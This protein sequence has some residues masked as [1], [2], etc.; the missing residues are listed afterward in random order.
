[1]SSP[2]SDPLINERVYQKDQS[3]P[4]PKQVEPIKPVDKT[5]QS[6]AKAIPKHEI[7]KPPVI[8]LSEADLSM[9]S[10]EQLAALASQYEEGSSN[11]LEIIAQKKSDLN[12][13]KT[14][15]PR[16]SPA[17]NQNPELHSSLREL[18]D[19]GFE[20]ELDKIA[21][22]I[23]HVL[24]AGETDLRS[25]NSAA[26]A[27]ISKINVAVSEKGRQPL[28][29]MGQRYDP[30]RGV[31]QV[32]VAQ[33]HA[34]LYQNRTMRHEGRDVPVEAI[35]LHPDA[36]REMLDQIV[37]ALTILIQANQEKEKDK[38]KGLEIGGKGVIG[39]ESART[40]EPSK[41]DTIKP[42][43]I[44][45]AIVDHLITAFSAKQSEFNKKMM[46]RFIKALEEDQEIVRE[47]VKKANKE[48]ANLK[49]IIVKA[50]QLLAE[51]DVA[52]IEHPEI[53]SMLNINVQQYYDKF[54]HQ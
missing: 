27:F 50:V 53:M 16:P 34:H 11:D 10:D 37:Q 54:K 30:R 15:A 35:A 2:A 45:Q 9:M 42:E 19:M 43:Q 39:R 23:A 17:I 13:H 29:K 7:P 18:Q 38:E 49:E 46:D 3:P 33:H 28:H 32:V 5:I 21:S 20:F 48:G 24:K 14:A 36:Y 26:A 51:K 44:K 40:E 4:S 8:D 47:A 6:V 31:M 22:D 12:Q 52:L 25:L 41:K 1:M